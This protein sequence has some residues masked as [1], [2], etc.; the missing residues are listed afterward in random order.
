MVRP[1]NA[2][3]WRVG[4]VV[5]LAGAVVVLGLS[6]AGRAIQS[7][8]VACAAASGSAATPP[9][10]LLTAQDYLAQG[11][12]DFD[13]GDCER[14]IADY[15]HAIELNSAFAEAYNNRAYTLMAKQDYARALTDL[16]MA[17]KIRPDYVNALMNRGDIHNYYYQ[18]D[19]DLAISDY[20]RVLELDPKSAQHTSV[21]G[22]LMLAEH[23]GWNA[24][25]LV[26]LLTRGAQAACTRSSPGY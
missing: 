23:H 20:E 14:A 12:Y 26:E 18:I 16:D 21:C 6:A 4:A 1:L 3:M 17:L 13:Q 9:A 22:H 5:V 2:K 10:A 8:P 19:Y 11:D 25:V 15:S 7:T 24:G